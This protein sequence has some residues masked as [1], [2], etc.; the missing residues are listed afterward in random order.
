MKTQKASLKKNQPRKEVSKT[1]VAIVL[2]VVIG[3]VCLIGYKVLF[4]PSKSVSREVLNKVAP[5][6]RSGALRN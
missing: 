3:I 5:L 6:R 4:S 2:A 1:T